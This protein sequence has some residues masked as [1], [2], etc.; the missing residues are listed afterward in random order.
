MTRVHQLFAISFVAQALWMLPIISDAAVLDVGTQY[1]LR[2]LSIDNPD[3]GAS[4]D[5][6]YSYMSQRA[7]FH[8]GGRFSP[9]I[10]MMTKFQAIGIA[11]SSGTVTEAA[12]NP[13]GN[14]LPRTDFTP[15]VQWAYLKATNLYDTPNTVTLGRQSIVLG[16]GML[17][18][19]DDLGFTG[20][21]L[22]SRLPWWGLQT[23]LFTF[24]TSDSIYDKNDGNLYGAQLVKPMRNIRYSLVFVSERDDSGTPYTRATENP[25][26]LPT[27]NL[28]TS[29][30]RRNF[31]GARIEG[32]LLEGGFFKGEF[33][34]QSGTI[35]RDPALES[36]KLGGYGM[37]LSAGLYARRSKFGPIEVHGMFG[38]GSGDKGDAGKDTAFRPSFSR[39]FD[40]MERIGYGEYYSASLFDSFQS[41]SNPRGVPAGHSGIRT[42]GGGI[43]MYPTR[44]LS[45]GVDYFVFDSQETSVTSFPTSSGETSLGSEFDFGMGFAYTEYLSFRASFAF[46][47][48]GNAYITKDKA[49]R[50]LFEAVGRF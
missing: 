47:S 43:T 26:T 24:K 17:L 10:E 42:I 50:F 36:V 49:R 27:T 30:I 44:L 34:T 22:E 19:D 31:Y 21:R 46:F 3:Y 18:S 14:R 8:I 41:S 6:S 4:P 28:A 11:G 7:L 9:N 35:K 45:I 29:H 32:R 37:T 39:R 23:D 20:I 33:A 40:G 1:R 15:F 5:R 25:A 13:G 38:L 16:D 2:A 12:A 48:P